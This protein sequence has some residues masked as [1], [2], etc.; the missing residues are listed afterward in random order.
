MI[1]GKAVGTLYPLITKVDPVVTLADSKDD[2]ATLWHK[3]LGHFGASGMIILHSNKVLTG[4]FDLNFDFCEDCVLGKQKRVTFTKDGRNKRTRRLELVH[5]DVWGPAH[6]KSYGGNSYFLTF[7]DDFSRKTWV[8]TIRQKADVFN[9]FKI[10]KAKVENKSG[11]K[12]KCLLSDN[13]G[14]YCNKEFDSYCEEK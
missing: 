10:W 4:V 6:E 14:E 13:G 3:R 5:T 12:L 8:F 7:I 1:K 2:N 11:C 9:T